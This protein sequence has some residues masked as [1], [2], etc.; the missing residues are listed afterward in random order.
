MAFLRKRFNCNLDTL[1][2]TDNSVSIYVRSLRFLLIGIFK[3][4]NRENPEFLWDMF[5]LGQ[6]RYPLRSGQTLALP[7]T[8]TQ[9]FGQ[10]SLSFRGSILWNGLPVKFKLV[11]STK[12]FKTAIKNWPGDTC[13]CYIC[14]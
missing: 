13:T 2:E 5:T 10:N 9:K 14:N 6:N 7:Q 4:L 3:T 1:L 11:D 12:H 8:K